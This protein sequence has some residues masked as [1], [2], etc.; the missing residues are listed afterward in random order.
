MFE[1]QIKNIHIFDLL[2][3]KL[4]AILYIN[5]NFKMSK[6]AKSWICSKNMIDLTMN[7]NEVNGKLQKLTQM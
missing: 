2:H 1:L 5:L 3:N 4:S 6:N 7:I